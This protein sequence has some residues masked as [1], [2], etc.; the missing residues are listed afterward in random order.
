MSVK[1][2]LRDEAHRIFRLFRGTETIFYPQRQVP[3]SSANSIPIGI[4]DLI[5]KVLN[6]SSSAINSFNNWGFQ[7]GNKPYGPR[8][9]MFQNGYGKL[10]NKK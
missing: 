9:Q 6:Q 1:L 2:V 5:F 3:A 4:D 10:R 7:F 8:R